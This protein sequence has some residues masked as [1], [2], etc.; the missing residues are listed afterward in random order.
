MDHRGLERMVL[1]TG[2]VG[3]YRKLQYFFAKRSILEP[4][5]QEHAMA[6]LKFNF[7]LQNLTQS[8]AL[9]FHTTELILNASVF[10]HEC[11]SVVESTITQPQ[12]KTTPKGVACL[13]WAIGDSNPGQTD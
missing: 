3:N 6:N 9:Y 11:L 5:C 12:K 7:Y 13:W 10:L 1:P 2:L 4:S 8:T